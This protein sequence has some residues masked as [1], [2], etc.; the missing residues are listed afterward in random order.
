MQFFMSF[1]GEQ[2]KQQICYSFTL[3]I[4][5]MV[6]N[7][8]KM[9]VQFYSFPN[10]DGPNAFFPKFNRPLPRLGKS[11][12]LFHFSTKTDVVGTRKNRLN[13]TQ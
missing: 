7:Q 12:Y 2:L 11:L 3:L 9:A 1:N 5:Y 10:F 8:F 6:L 4:S 13:Q